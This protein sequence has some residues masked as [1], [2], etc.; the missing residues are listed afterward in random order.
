MSIL[1]LFC[2]NVDDV[3]MLVWGFPDQEMSDSRGI[4]R[5]SCTLAGCDCFGYTGGSDGMKCLR[6]LHP[7]G[8]HQNLTTSVPAA[9]VQSGVGQFQWNTTSGYHNY[10][11]GVGN[12]AGCMCVCVCV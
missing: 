3:I 7:P 11:A 1:L 6:C 8:K 5:G 2:T 12:T 10:S 4:C 9:S